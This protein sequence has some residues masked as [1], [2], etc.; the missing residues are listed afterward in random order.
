MDSSNEWIMDGGIWTWR[1]GLSDGGGLLIDNRKSK[2]L[3]ICKG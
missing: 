3:W 1:Q 2:R